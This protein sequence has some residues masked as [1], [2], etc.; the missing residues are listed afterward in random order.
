[1]DPSLGARTTTPRLID[2]RPPRS[3]SINLIKGYTYSI[4]EVQKSHMSINPTLLSRRRTSRPHNQGA[5]DTVPEM[6]RFSSEGRQGTRSK[7]QHGNSQRLGAVGSAPPSVE[8]ESMREL[9]EFLMYHPPPP[10]NLRPPTPETPKRKFSLFGKKPKKAPKQSELLQLPDTAVAARTGKG[11]QYIAISIPSQHDYLGNLMKTGCSTPPES[12]S[13]PRSPSSGNEREPIVVQKPLYKPKSRNIT[14]PPDLQPIKTNDSRAVRHS[15]APGLAH[16]K[17]ALEEAGSNAAMSSSGY[18]HHNQTCP[19][20]TSIYAVEPHS[21]NVRSNTVT[22]SQVRRTSF[23]DVRRNNSMGSIHPPLP[24]SKKEGPLK[25][26]NRTPSPHTKPA[27]QGHK[28][29]R[30]RST[31]HSVASTAAGISK[32]LKST[33]ESFASS[34]TATVF[35]T[36]ETVDFQSIRAGSSL[37]ALTP[38]ERPNLTLTTSRSYVTTIPVAPPPP[39]MPHVANVAVNRSKSN[40]SDQRS[41]VSSRTSRR[42]RVRARR[43]RDLAELR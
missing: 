32:S 41:E 31:V 23:Q 16:N 4:S 28:K 34:P 13:E 42:D 10:E 33:P 21:L 38:T 15:W 30:S 40:G 11:V 26:V 22:S 24:T 5:I 6:R 39:P 37:P 1:M 9:A 14:P 43:E 8:R 18:F 27:H 36:A 29:S 2:I 35:G 17:D 7:S 25:V 3:P 19:P 20:P 12:S